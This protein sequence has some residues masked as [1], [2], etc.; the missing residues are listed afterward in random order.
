MTTV[1][2]NTEPRNPQIPTEPFGA[3][4]PLSPGG[5]HPT[6]VTTARA[7]D[8]ARLGFEIIQDLVLFHSH[9]LQDRIIHVHVTGVTM[10]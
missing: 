9:G 10:I 4:V 7:C 3:W 2:V 6:Q 8:H 1:S 5:Q